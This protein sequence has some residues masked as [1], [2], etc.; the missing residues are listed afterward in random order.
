MFISVHD[1]KNIMKSMSEII[2]R[3]ELLF[4]EFDAA[5]GDGDFGTSL[6]KGFKEV[7]KGIDEF[8][9]EDIGKFLG[10]CSM[11][12]FEYCGGASGPIWGSAFKAAARTVK[13]KTELIDTDVAD[14]LDSAIDG[15]QKKGGAS[16]GDKT[17][18][19]AL[20]PAAEALRAC[21]AAGGTLKDAFSEAA[22][23]AADGA[24]KTKL[25]IAKKGRATYVG[26]RSISYPDA[27]AMAIGIIFNELIQ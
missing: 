21:I 25:I 7:L 22:K 27:G 26:E 11:V 2:I 1:V 24:E 9:T 8:D 12:I 18:L 6:A 5:A 4:C 17:L 16:L 19:D 23:A 14:L 13:G 15:I 20:I 10:D 3:N